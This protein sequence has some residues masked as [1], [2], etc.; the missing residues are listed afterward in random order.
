MKLHGETSLSLPSY[1]DECWSE[2]MQA[3][4][5]PAGKTAQIYYQHLA[6]YYLAIKGMKSYHMLCPLRNL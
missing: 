6:E 1:G 3:P 2:K 4:I 5:S